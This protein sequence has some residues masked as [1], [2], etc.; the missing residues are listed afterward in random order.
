MDV[1][2]RSYVL[3]PVSEPQMTTPDEVHEAIKGIKLSKFPGPNGIPN[4]ALKHLPKRAVS[5]L[6]RIL[7]AELRTQLSP[8]V[9]ARSSDLYP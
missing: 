8:I 4:R 6:A 5:F 2:L 1:A 7:N 3:S 9:E